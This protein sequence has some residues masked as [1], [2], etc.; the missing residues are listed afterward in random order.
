[1]EAAVN[2]FSMSARN[3]M[4]PL[5]NRTFMFLVFYSRFHHVT[6]NLIGTAGIVCGAG[7]ESI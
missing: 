3:F 7:A 6:C 5:F 1:M 2:D 4:L